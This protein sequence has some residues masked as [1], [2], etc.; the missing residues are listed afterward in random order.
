MWR[1]KCDCGNFKNVDG[2]HLRSGATKS[3]GCILKE[4]MSEK[5]TTHGLSSSRLYRIWSAMVNRCKNENTPCYCRYGG[6]GIS[7]CEE[8]KVFESFA[9]WAF[10]AGYDLNSSYQTIDR[11]DVNKGYCPDN[12]RWATLQEQANNTRSNH[13]LEFNGEIH[14][15]ADW[16]RISGIPYTT[17][18]NRINVLRWPVERALTEPVKMKK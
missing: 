5:K 1:C 11:I 6:R 3:C 15:M 12:C 10:S 14:S 17:L 9:K 18:R 16:A 7:V 2:K 4:M 8:W 13:C